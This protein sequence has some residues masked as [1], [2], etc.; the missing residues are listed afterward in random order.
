MRPAFLPLSAVVARSLPAMPN[1]PCRGCGSIERGM[2][3]V[4]ESVES[5]HGANG[6]V[7]P[8]TAEIAWAMAQNAVNAP[9]Q[10]RK[11]SDQ[12]YGRGS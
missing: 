3:S 5:A 6:D 12:R 2:R 4:T 7:C 9:G 10:I 8:G 1:Q 11:A